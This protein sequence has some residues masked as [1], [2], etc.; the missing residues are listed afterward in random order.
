MFYDKFLKTL[1]RLT[2]LN[3]YN[4]RQ[5]GFLPQGQ[6]KY[7]QGTDLTDASNPRTAAG[8]DQNKESRGK[9]HSCGGGRGVYEDL[10]LKI[11]KSYTLNAG[12]WKDN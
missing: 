3:L 1:S 4:F 5:I 10:W 11:L 12:K 8:R 2:F 7:R 9:Y 6:E